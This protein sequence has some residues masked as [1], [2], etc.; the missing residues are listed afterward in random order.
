MV[1]ALGYCV[2]VMGISISLG[3]IVKKLWIVCVKG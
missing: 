1:G 3:R 2:F